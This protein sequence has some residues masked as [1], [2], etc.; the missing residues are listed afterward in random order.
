MSVDAEVV[1]V[2]AGIAGSLTAL[3]LARR[4]RDVLLVERGAEPGTKNLSGGVLFCRVLDEIVPDFATTAPV[5][6]RV[7]RHQLALLDGDAC[8]GL[9]FSDPRLADPVNAVTVLRSRL[10][11]WLVAQAEAAGVGVLPG[12][13]VDALVVE[14][15]QVVGVRAG[16][17]TLRAHAV[18]AA[19][20]VNSFLARAAGLRAPEPPARLALGVKSVIGLPRTVLEERFRLSG[21][22]GV[23]ATFLGDATAGVAG[24][25]FLYTN[26]E[27]V[28]VGVVLRLDDLTARGL[29]SA[30]VHDRFL[31]HPSV[32]PLLAGGELLE[33]GSHLTLEDGPAS[34]SGPLARPGLVL[35]GD[36]AGLTLNT[37]LAI[38][39]MDLAAGSALVA[40]SAVEDAL[41][42]GDPAQLA[43]TYPAALAASP[44]G[45]DLRTFAAAPRALASERL[46]GLYPRLAADLLRRAYAH[47]G[48]PRDHLAR[49]ARAAVRE[50][51][52]GPLALARDALTL[53]R[54]L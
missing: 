48:A 38:R 45:A 3:L 41:A 13:R 24:G 8:V 18:V 17:D 37:G 20:G 40:A 1:V 2:G 53:G 6:R 34:A 47:D 22:A 44:V 33:Y 14:D 12:V 10:D 7:V 25:G 35:V 19:D 11:P 28:S 39:G 50:S 26:R 27:S 46:S 15:G 54:A 52:V 30:D 42:A 51:G 36:A 32:A 16:D 43:H 21:E 49:L 5:E 4:G 29:S 23:A 9:E 31:T